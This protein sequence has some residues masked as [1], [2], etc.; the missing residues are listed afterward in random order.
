[1]D[2]PEE[3]VVAAIEAE[4]MTLKRYNRV[5]ELTGEYQSIRAKVTELVLE[6]QSQDS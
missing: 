1:M 4:G 2:K 5:V 3:E 6:E